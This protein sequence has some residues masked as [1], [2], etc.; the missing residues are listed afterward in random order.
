MAP[1]MVQLDAVAH[2]SVA[3]KAREICLPYFAVL[4]G[5]GDLLCSFDRVNAASSKHGKEDSKEW[6]HTDQSG[7]LEGLACIQ[8]FL[9]VNGTGDVDGGL[10]VAVGSHRAHFE[11]LKKWDKGQK[12]THWYL[13]RPDERYF[14]EKR[15]VSLI[16]HRVCFV[17]FKGVKCSSTT[18]Q[19][20]CS[21][22][23]DQSFFGTAEHFT[24][25]CSLK[26][27]RTG[28]SFTAA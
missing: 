14:L 8:G 10:R 17:S 28:S 12:K 21:V 13:L 27:T 4:W 15:H 22:P 6:L 26:G 23:P 18:R 7:L 24:T 11:L 5:T 9:D 3:W 19:R 2:S 1:R 16:H 20:K 25:T